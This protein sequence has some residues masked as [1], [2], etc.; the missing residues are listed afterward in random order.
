MANAPIKTNTLLHAATET[1]DRSGL[2]TQLRDDEIHEDAIAK[3]AHQLWLE[4]GSPIGS[5]EED[6]YRAEGLLREEARASSRRV[7]RPKVMQA[8]PALSQ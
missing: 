2:V 1:Q 3:L 5:P 8:G 4:R 7:L 6:W